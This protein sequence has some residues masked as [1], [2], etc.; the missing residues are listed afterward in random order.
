MLS[1]SLNKTFLSLSLLLQVVEDQSVHICGGR[2]CRIVY[3]LYRGLP[4]FAQMG[5]HGTPL[6][7]IWVSQ[8][9]NQESYNSF[10]A[11]ALPQSWHRIPTYESD[12]WSQGYLANHSVWKVLLFFFFSFFSFFFSWW[13]T[14]IWTGLSIYC[15]IPT[16]VRVVWIGTSNK[17]TKVSLFI[18][19]WIVWSNY[20]QPPL[21][22]IDSWK[23][24]VDKCRNIPEIKFYYSKLNMLNKL[25]FQSYKALETLL[26]IWE[27]KK[28]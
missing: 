16:L 12:F 8:P 5:V 9:E 22:N 26:V 4:D 19:G 3:G 6:I 25:R 13:R 28:S 11:F 24:V 10:T 14:R 18:Y 20:I 15:A 27:K 21:E 2:L 23:L 17:L 7:I 1:A